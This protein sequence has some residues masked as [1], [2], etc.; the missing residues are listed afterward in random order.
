MATTKK[1][2]HHRRRTTHRADAKP[3]LVSPANQTVVTPLPPKAEPSPPPPTERP[4][5]VLIKKTYN[6]ERLRYLYMAGLVVVTLVAVGVIWY[7]WPT[8][9]K[10]FSRPDMGLADAIQLKVKHKAIDQQKASSAL[11]QAS[12]SASPA[13]APDNG[14][15]TVVPIYEGQMSSL[16]TA[17]LYDQLDA[18]ISQLNKEKLNTRV[19]QNYA[20]QAKQA[21][22]EEAARKLLMEGI[23][24]AKERQA[25]YGYYGK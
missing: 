9:V 8:I 7:E 2:T 16:S 3:V 1:T 10:S 21:V 6:Q 11:Q 19:Y 12:L 5:P 15:T 18:R 23:Q 24:A 14:A 4:A 20:T 13:A 25:L 17:D 22:S